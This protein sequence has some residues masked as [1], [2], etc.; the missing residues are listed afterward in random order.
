MNNINIILESIG[1]TQ[2]FLIRRMCNTNFRN[3]KITLLN[4]LLNDNYI[5]FIDNSTETD[6]E[7]LSSISYT[8][9][10]VSMI[11]TFKNS[12]VQKVLVKNFYD[13]S[14]TFANEFEK[15]KQISNVTSLLYGNKSKGFKPMKPIE[16]SVENLFFE[17]HSIIRDIDGL[18]SDQALD[19]I[20]KFIYAKLYDEETIYNS[21]EKILQK[22]LYVTT[23]EVAS[24]VRSVY[25]KSTDYDDRIYSLRI[26][27]YKKSRGVFDSDIKLSSPAL[28]KLVELF[29][30]IDLTNS[31]IDVKGRAFQKM[32]LPSMRA[33]M[34]QYFTPLPII[35]FIVEVLSPNADDLIIDP[36]SGSGHFLTEALYNV[37]N[38]K[39][40]ISEKKLYEFKFH[41]LHGIEKS[42]RMV[43]I[44]M[45]D[46][47]LHGDGHSN[48]RCTDALLSFDN[49]EDLKENSFD[50]VMSN[51][52]FGSTLTIEAIDR[53]DS[54]ELTKGRKSVPLEILGL[55]RCIQLL[56]PGGRLGIVLPESIITNKST[57]YVRDWLLKNFR[58][59]GIIELPLETFSP[60]G[61]NIKTIVLFGRKN[62]IG[63]LKQ[64]SNDV[65]VG[66]IKSVGYDFKGHP[67][68]ENDI[69]TLIK[70]LKDFF[71][72]YGKLQNC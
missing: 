22:M 61:A 14:F 67:I 41:K 26:P 30:D 45:T 50:L 18:H 12:D 66:K 4:N 5:L 54:F 46:M 9:P 64:D 49:Y 68:S 38:N 17:A 57:K 31:N 71:E 48:I 62:K 69:N 25:K 52:P 51:P 8:Y 36:F 42:D 55:E 23:E 6:N 59:Y 24:V 7:F 56:R 40:Q 58:L 27:K 72:N 65:I 11:V 63:E 33:G 34:G 70:P 60:F 13:N 35:K 10:S 1:Y 43:R 47:R 3:S 39:N 20:C 32:L 19:E 28:Y 21:G 16:S 29:E 2:D 15:P 44:S 37:I 53:L